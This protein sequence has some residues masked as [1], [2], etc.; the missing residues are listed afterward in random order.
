MLKRLSQ[1]EFVVASC[2]LSVI[3]LLVFA[4]SILRFFDHPLVWSVDLAQLLF[5]W[6]CFFGATRAMRQKAHIGIDIAVRALPYRWRLGCEFVVSLI[7]I[8][9]LCALTYQGIKLTLLNSARQFGDS[10]LSYG[11]VTAAVPAGSLMLIVA[12]ARNLLMAFRRRG[13]GTTLVYTRTAGENAP[14]SEL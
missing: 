11:W 13:D 1:L 4:A 5:I 7:I 10:G 14:A 2:L 12:L 8:A 9:F 6:L 3:V